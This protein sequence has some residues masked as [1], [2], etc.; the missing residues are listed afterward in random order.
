MLCIT[1]N[2]VQNYIVVYN[3]TGTVEAPTGAIRAKFRK[4]HSL[5]RFQKDSAACANTFN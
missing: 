1:L 5:D 3:E 2:N 4:A